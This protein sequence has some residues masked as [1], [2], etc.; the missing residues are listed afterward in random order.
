MGSGTNAIFCNPWITSAMAMAM[1]I[2]RTLCVL[3]GFVF[4]FCICD[5]YLCY[6]F[7]F[8]TSENVPYGGIPLKSVVGVI[9]WVPS[10]S[11]CCDVA[12]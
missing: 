8:R 4:V 6:V 2:Y 10:P 7:V 12:D 5:L 11:C 1:S 3:Y 9:G